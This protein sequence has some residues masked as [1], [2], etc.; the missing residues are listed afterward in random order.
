[1]DSIAGRVFRMPDNLTDNVDTDLILPGAYLR[2]PEHELGDYAFHGVLP[3]FRDRLAGRTVLVSGRN[4]GCGS[5]REQAPKALLGC[6][7]RLIIAESFGNIFYRNCFN[8]GIVLV[9]VPGAA[10]HPLF[11]DDVEVRADLASGALHGPNG[12]LSTEPLPNHLRSIV[13]AGGILTL[14]SRD[15]AALRR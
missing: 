2:I 4:F 12:S 7:V 11:A 5:S 8:L 9:R 10:S 1:M 6:G 14:L 13:G 3:G 15:P